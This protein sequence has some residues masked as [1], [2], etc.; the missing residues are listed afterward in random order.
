MRKVLIILLLFLTLMLVSCGESNDSNGE[1][2]NNT[3]LVET[4]SLGGDDILTPPV[5][6]DEDYYD[7]Y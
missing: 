2:I 1:D 5:D 6:G 4:P 3:T 7:Y